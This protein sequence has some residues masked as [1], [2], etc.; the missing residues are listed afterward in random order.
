MLIR[1][2]RKGAEVE[3]EKKIAQSCLNCIQLNILFDC[4]SYRQIKNKLT[5][6]KVEI[7]IA[8][9]KYSVMFDKSNKHFDCKDVNKNAWETVAKKID[10]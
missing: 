9:Q 8:V 3:K 1:K 7:S 6:K 10:F 5:A 2:Q 4:F